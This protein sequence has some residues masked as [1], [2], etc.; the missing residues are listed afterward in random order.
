M[1]QL[2]SF[3]VW[4]FT[5]HTSLVWPKVSC[6]LFFLYENVSLSQYRGTRTDSP[7]L[8]AL[9]KAL[10]WEPHYLE[11]WWSFHLL[12]KAG[13]LEAQAPIARASLEWNYAIEYNEVL[14]YTGVWF[15]RSLWKDERKKKVVLDSYCGAGTGSL[16]IHSNIHMFTACQYKEADVTQLS[17]K[18]ILFICSVVNIWIH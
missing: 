8:G 4:D 15:I 18:L 7:F 13:N 5:L 2:L 11:K 1:L 9:G 12:Y 17:N 3:F 14:L 10:H 16:L 6:I